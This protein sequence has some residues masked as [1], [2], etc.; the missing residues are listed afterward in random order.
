MTTW[1]LLARQA[2]LTVMVPRY[3][4]CRHPGCVEAQ[5]GFSFWCRWHTDAILHGWDPFADPVTVRYDGGTN[6]TGGIP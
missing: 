3:V 4:P 6:H 5:V 1:R 2:W